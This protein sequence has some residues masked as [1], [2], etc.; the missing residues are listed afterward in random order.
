MEDGFYQPRHPAPALL[1][2]CPVCHAPASYT[3]RARNEVGLWSTVVPHA[4]RAAALRRAR[5]ANR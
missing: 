3:C 5:E 1:V 2:P 4:D